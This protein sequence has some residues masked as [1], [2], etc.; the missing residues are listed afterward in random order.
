MS[1]VENKTGNP[2]PLINFTMSD[3]F[4]L[5]A[6]FLTVLF[7]GV[8]QWAVTLSIHTSSGASVRELLAA[9]MFLLLAALAAGRVVWGILNAIRTPRT[10]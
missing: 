7:L 5:V 4:T 6:A 8:S 10:P 3:A 2:P 9:L 1:E